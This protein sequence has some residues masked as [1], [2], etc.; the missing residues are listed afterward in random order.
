MRIYSLGS[1]NIDYVYGVDHFVRAGET[2]SSSQMNIY[3]GGKGLN[4]SI[5]AARA[6]G[7]VLH[8]VVL[9]DNGVFLLETLSNS[10]VDTSRI[11]TV[12]GSCGHA[13]IQVDKSGQ[14]SILLFPGTNYSVDKAY[15]QRFLRDAEAGDFLILQNE[16]SALGEIMELAHEKKMQIALNPS[17]LGDNISKLP[18]QYVKWWFCNEIEGAALFGGE[19]VDALTRNFLSQYPDANLILTLGKDGSI[20][21]NRT[22]RIAQPIYPVQAVDTTAAGDTFAGYFIAAVA[23]GKEIAFAMDLAARASSITVSR[24]GASSSIPYRREL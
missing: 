12:G 6:G 24:P 9:G 4:Q 11:E 10:G 18:L 7:A 16:I 22:Q 5:A 15:A 23:E 3:P 14:N 8:G 2:L 21:V 19:N 20:F 17:P 1:V 13:I